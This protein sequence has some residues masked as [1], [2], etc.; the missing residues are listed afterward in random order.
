MDGQHYVGPS[1]TVLFYSI[2][3][4]PCHRGPEGSVGIEPEEAEGTALAFLYHL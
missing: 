1:R 4:L 3:Y 2:N